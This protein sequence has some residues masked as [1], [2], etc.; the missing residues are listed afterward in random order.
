MSEPALDE[1]KEEQT[2]AR[3]RPA[4]ARIEHHFK[5]S[6]IWLVPIGAAGIAAYLGVHALV[7]RGPL[8]EITFE[9][10]A[11]LR[12]HQ[13][14]VRHKDVTLGTVDEVSLSKD[15]SHVIVEVRM[16][17]AAKSL[18][19]DHAK[20]W[21][22]RPRLSGADL[23]RL[24]TGL[25]TIV[26]G[27]Y[28]GVDPGAPGGKRKEKFVGLEEPPA[29]RS[30]EPG[31]VYSLKAE[32][33]G[34]LGTGAPVFYRD[35]NV[36]EV[37]KQD[38]GDGTGPVAIRIFVRAPFD[39][40]VQAGTRF[41]NASGLSLNMGPEGLHLELQSL[42][43][44]LA[45]GVAFANPP[46][47][48]ATDSQGRTDKVFDLYGSKE[49]AEADFFA[50]VPCVTYFESSVAGLAIGAQ[51]Q[52]YG[53]QIGVVTDSRLVLDE[54]GRVV[55]RVAFDLQPGRALGQTPLDAGRA[56][57]RAKL[58][59]E[60]GLG[61]MLSSTN[62]VTGQKVL[63]LEYSSRGKPTQVRTEG[64]AF[65]LPGEGGGLENLTSSLSAVAT[66]LN[67]IPFDRIGEN[68]DR[69]LRA[70][71]E[72]VNGPKLQEAL[73]QFGSA[74]SEVR[75]LAHDA[76]SGLKPALARLPALADEVQSAAQRVHDAL[77][78]TGYGQDSD[79]QRGIERFVMQASDAVRNVK[80]LAEFLDEHPEALLRGRAGKGSR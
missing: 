32:R 35:V 6:P 48:A 69:T 78:A 19:T 10:G 11:G 29:F 14:E 38:V 21:V 39:E 17:A 65:V 15:M 80:Q 55:V 25:E 37:L 72:T 40:L 36:G 9:T 49:L 73:T 24:E 76:D 61:V 31:H 45:G 2:G 64:D 54:R 67:K 56:R 46:R 52:I 13:T 34:S 1:R 42:Q 3:E 68:V 23:A 22:V 66:K 26:S 79:F 8:V 5:L 63:S 28:I 43:S 51:V 62:F 75:N 41:W 7:E 4:V 71:S 30:D 60:R 47:G 44:L 33:L 53:V 70:V 57:A 18:L 77:G 58:L 59:V 74:L 50:R 16:Q 27:A 20:F 12:A